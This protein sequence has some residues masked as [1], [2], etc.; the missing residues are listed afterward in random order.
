M[1]SIRVLK[2]AYNYVVMALAPLVIC[3]SSAASAGF[4]PRSFT[5]KSFERLVIQQSIFV[6]EM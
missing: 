1:R 2:W 6:G 4:D 3:T 5:I